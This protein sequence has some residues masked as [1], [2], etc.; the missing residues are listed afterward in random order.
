MKKANTKIDWDFYLERK[1]PLFLAADFFMTYGKLL[2]KV[3][4][5]S[6]KNHLFIYEK[7]TSY[8]YRSKKELLSA[9]KY[10][11]KLI[12]KNDKRLVIWRNECLKLNRK[13]DKLVQ[14][15]SNNYQFTEISKNY[16]NI[17]RECQEIIL[18]GTVITY[19][20]LSAINY[21]VEKGEDTKKYKKI[22]NLYE[23][24]RRETRYP[25]LYGSVYVA[26]WKTAA[27][28]T[29]TKDYKLFSYATPDEIGEIIK[30]GKKYN[31]KKKISEIKKRKKWCVF[32]NYKSKI[33]FAY[34]KSILK[35]LG[36]SGNLVKNIKEIR[37][38]VACQGHVTGKVRIV[39]SI[40]EMK[41]FK[42]GEI[43]V[44]I[45]T[46]PSL[47]PAIMKCAGI[48]TD[49]GGMMCHA[50]IVSREFKKPCIIGTK[51]AT[52]ILKNGTRVD[53]DAIHGKVRIL[54]K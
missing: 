14:K 33:K 1:Q 17:L 3:T 47:M 6:F 50:A 30:Y 53:L 44:S 31:I 43:M 10:Y 54:D 42:K 48:I 35:S 29:K 18:Y 32:Y 16:E 22:I 36:I 8:A 9:D 38:R 27:K 19:R 5:F 51:I 25:Q 15:F 26:F 20:I 13:A 45:N 37:G 4:G 28:I 21:A 12:Q 52:K 40:R 46:N 2:K 24:L 41:N 49:E 23:P 7:G 34:N 11:L 39:N